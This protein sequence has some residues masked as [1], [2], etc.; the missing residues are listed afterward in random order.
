MSVP[1]SPEQAEKK[2]FR[3]TFDDGLWDVLLGCFIALF[4]LAPLLSARMGDFW[5][6]VVFL[7]FWGVVY[8]AIR[9]IRRY[10][11]APRIGVV[12]YGRERK[13]RLARFTVVMLVVNVATLVLGFIAA[14][15]IGKVPGGTTTIAF[16]LILLAGFSI[17]AYFLDFSRL[18]IY[19]LMLAL[20]PVVGEKLFAR[21]FA[22]HHGFPV[23][24]GTT[25]SVMA[26]V[27]IAVFARLLRDNPVPAG[28]DSSEEA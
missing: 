20:S 7:P 13:A 12:R 8:L 10:V 15:N 5:S 2:A 25:A 18:Y 28:G 21:G 3:S 17:A 1:L 24:F 11:V 6:S 4:A 23:T 19:G 22:S 26:I 16:G 14:A 9:L 27:G